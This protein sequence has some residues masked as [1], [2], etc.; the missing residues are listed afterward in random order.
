VV[1]ADRKMETV[2]STKSETRIGFWNVRT[3]NKIGRLGQVTSETRHYNLYILRF[4][5]SRWMGSG[6]DSELIQERQF[7]TQEEMATNKIRRWPSSSGKV[8]G[9]A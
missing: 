1:K 9:I 8:Q 2:L 5:E 7:K 4:I 3:M 6:K